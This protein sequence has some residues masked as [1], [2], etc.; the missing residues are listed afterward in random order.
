MEN[1]IN[2][3]N[4]DFKEINSFKSLYDLSEKNSSSNITTENLLN[5]KNTNRS[6]KVNVNLE[7]GNIISYLEEDFK[8]FKNNISLEKR[9]LDILNNNVQS[10]QNDEEKLI[11][12]ENNF[13][14]LNSRGNLNDYNIN[15]NKDSNYNMSIISENKISNYSL[16][17]NN[18][19]NDEFF[20]KN[21]IQ[22]FYF[23]GN[24]KGMIIRA[25]LFYSGVTWENRKVTYTEWPNIKE[26]FE[27]RQLPALNYYGKLLT[28]SFAI[29]NFLAKKF[30]L[31]GKG[32]EE[33]AKIN[34]LLDIKNDLIAKLLQVIYPMNEFDKGFH[35]LEKNFEILFI[36]TLPM[37]LKSF[38]NLLKENFSLNVKKNYF[39]KSGFSLA[40]IILTV[41]S[42]YIFKHPLRRTL[43][44]SL[45][46]KYAPTLN[47]FIDKIQFEHLYGFFNYYFSN[48][49]A[50]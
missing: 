31:M 11:L 29:E 24:A 36:N 6:T 16:I 43:F 34:S 46:D 12:I 23:E 38:E 45:L 21:K 48:D 18:H 3:K 37:Y 28:Q 20:N 4:N 35:I 13:S 5:D 39:L 50:I 30:N 42:H 22:I 27:Y 7:N 8:G 41:I 25:L 19:L 17:S 2:I 15:Q 26:I 9:E 47:I 10:P 14:L 40:D 1:S 33:E 32:P 44:E 49:I